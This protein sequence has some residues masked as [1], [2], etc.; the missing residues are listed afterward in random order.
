MMR[1]LTTKGHKAAFG[2]EGHV[3]CF[4]CGGGRATLSVRI[5]R[6]GHRKR[7]NFLHVHYI[8]LHLILNMSGQGPVAEWV[9]R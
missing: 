5:Y 6:M 8:S 7:V 2:G 1:E 3:L 4:D 9:Y